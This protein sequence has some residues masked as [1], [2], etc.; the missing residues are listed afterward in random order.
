MK[1]LSGHTGSVYSLVVLPDGS[2]ASNS[3]DINR[4]NK[5]ISLLNVI[6]DI[7]IYSSY[8]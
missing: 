3:F 7:L 8:F 5:G 1:T 6:F 4:I 2:F